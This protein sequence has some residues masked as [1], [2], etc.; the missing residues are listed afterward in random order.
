MMRKEEIFEKIK[1]DS[2]KLVK[3]V[4]NIKKLINEKIIKKEDNINNK[5]NII[6]NKFFQKSFSLKSKK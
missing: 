2:K 6:N 1:L 4:R 3:L 5:K